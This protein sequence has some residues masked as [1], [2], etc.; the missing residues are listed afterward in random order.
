MNYTL[1]A[2]GLKFRLTPYLVMLN[3]RHCSPPPGGELL[4]FLPSPP[5]KKMLNSFTI[6]DPVVFFLFSDWVLS[7]PQPVHRL[8]SGH[9][10]TYPTRPHISHS[11]TPPPPSSL[12]SSHST[13]HQPT[14]FIHV[15]IRTCHSLSVGPSI[16][17]DHRFSLKG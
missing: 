14:S 1:F 3:Y 15:S 7:A 16:S 4:A 5:Q 12:Q 13:S 17:P 2:L 8:S 9:V 10:R 11:A 6:S